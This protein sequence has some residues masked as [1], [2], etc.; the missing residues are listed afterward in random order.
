M[1]IHKILNNISLKISLFL[2][3][4]RIP[5]S[6]IFFNKFYKFLIVKK[7][8]ENE[9]IYNFHNKGYG[10]LKINLNEGLNKFKDSFKISENKK[11]V[12][13]E[14][15][16]KRQY[17]VVEH[18]KRLEFKSFLESSLSS[19]INDLSNY[20]KSNVTINNVQIFRIKN[21]NNLEIQNKE[22]YSNYFHQ[23]AYLFTYIKIFVNLMDISETEGPLEIVSINNSS[24]F[25]KKFNYKDRNKYKYVEDPIVYKN[26]G[27]AGDCFLFSS[28]QCFH[29]AGIPNKHRDIMQIIL[30]ASPNTNEKNSDLESREDVF[31]GNDKIASSAKPY[32]VFRT[33]KLFIDHLFHSIR[34]KYN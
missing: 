9:E 22:I 18:N 2:F 11:S 10:K 21:E 1:K 32:S 20:Y 23:D 4:Q 6:Y 7:K 34:Y 30:L 31:E 29:K 17:F 3:N 16:D 26:T 25:I 8:I 12:P 5:L 28:A 14:K 27:K 19:T 15:I 33:I 24:K 13:G